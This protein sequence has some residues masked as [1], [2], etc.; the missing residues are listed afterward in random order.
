MELR[1][2]MIQT[3]EEPDRTL[4]REIRQDDPTPASDRDLL[5]AG[6]I[7]DHNQSA[8][9][10]EGVPKNW[11][12][13]SEEER[14]NTFRKIDGLEPISLPKRSKRVSVARSTKTRRYI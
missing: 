6:R 5:R 9:A 11:S 2:T 14:V 10:F 13:Q 1:K 12:K 7:L 4:L 3:L 8:F